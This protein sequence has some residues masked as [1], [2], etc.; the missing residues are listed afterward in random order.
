MAW[1]E[2]FLCALEGASPR[3]WVE[4]QMVQGV[5]QSLEQLSVV[6]TSSC[7][8]SDSSR[9]FSTKSSNAGLPCSKTRRRLFLRATTINKIGDLMAQLLLPE[10]VRPAEV[11]AVTAELVRVSLGS[12]CRPALDQSTKQ[13]NKTGS[14]HAPNLQLS[15]AAPG[16][17]GGRHR[18]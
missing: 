17:D 7:A 4:Q 18:R 12:A 14:I 1:Q 13:P 15:P 10:A 5:S 6:P 2:L 8:G 9:R 3:V 16:G 11:E